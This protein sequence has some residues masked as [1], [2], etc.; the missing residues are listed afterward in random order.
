MNEELEQTEE[1]T[2]ETFGETP[3]EE[4][5]ETTPE[6]ISSPPEEEEEPAHELSKPP[7]IDLKS[8]LTPI[9]EE[10]P[11]GEY[12]RYS[13]VY[14]E[15]GEARREDEALGK[16]DL[17]MELKTA[18]FSRVIELAVPVLE[19]ESKDLQISAWLAEAL[20]REHEFT[21]LRD[22]LKLISGLQEKFWETLYP[23]IDEGDM[24]GRANAIAWMDN[25]A[26]LAI[27]EAVIIDGEGYSYLD[28][29]DSK[30]YN[31]PDNL[32]MLE[33]EE[34]NKYKALEAEAIKQNKVTAEKWSKAVAATRRAFS[35]ELNIAI[36]ECQEELQRLNRVIE[37]HFDVNQSPSLRNLQKI[38]LDIATE[39]GK[40]LKLK[41]EEEPDE[42]DDELFEGE[43]SE[44]GSDGSAR[45]SA[46]SARGTIQNRQDALKR[47]SE[48]ADFFRKTE[49]HSPVSYLV[50]RA[51]KWGNMPLESWLQDVI[52]DESILFQIRQTLGF[53][54]NTESADTAS[55]ETA[56]SDESYT[57]NQGEYQ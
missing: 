24:E 48:L 19:K 25:Q 43:E 20:V 46:S 30:K 52:K 1:I 3:A 23:E 9:S 34:Q 10:K 16:E 32:E 31:F 37:E 27:M 41:R 14:D 56:G 44:A 7:V 45:G 26:A 17:G 4:S 49:P 15:I 53:N 47:L 35:E 57:E 13:G 12:M 50:T 28:Y 11:S 38:L 39:T 18:D 36:E 8:L 55:A 6:G 21:G 29:Q 54:T 33:Y 40:V 2:E 5:A 51:V 22:S 42:T